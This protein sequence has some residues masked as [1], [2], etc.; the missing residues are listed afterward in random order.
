[1]AREHRLYPLLL[2][3]GNSGLR[4]GELA[5]LRWADI[6]LTTGMLV[7]RRQRKSINYRVIEADA[8]SQAGQDRVVMLGERTIKGLKSWKAKQSAERLAWGPAYHDGGYV[9]T[10]EDGIPYHPDYLSH[11]VGKLM[12]RAGIADAKLH[13]L[14]HF[15][16]AA[17][18]SAGYDIDAVSKALGHS[19]VAITS[20][21][22]SSL[23]NVA[24]AAM[25]ARAE[26]LVWRGRT[27]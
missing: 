2:L 21:I 16:A 10:R 17:L 14:R 20:L 11:A 1:M 6:N 23:F 4:R 22:Y 12:R 15:Y 9:F 5:G 27:A 19:S 24:K 3:A 7:V 26:D 8:K 25:A 13:T 18:I